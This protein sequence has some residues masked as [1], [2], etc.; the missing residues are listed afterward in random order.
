[1]RRTEVVPGVWRSPLPTARE[2]ADFSRDG[3]KTVVD[4]TRRPRPSIERA[5]AKYALAYR[6]TPLSYIG[7]FSHSEMES[8]VATVLAAETPCLFHCFHGRD[9]TG[10]VARRLAMSVGAVW[11]YR[12]GRNLNRAIRTCEAFNVC[13]LVLVDCDESFISGRLFGAS[14]RVTIERAD[15]LPGDECLPIET[16]GDVEIR[17]VDWAPVRGI[18]IGGET[19]GL[20][21]RVGRSARID[22]GG[23]VS[24]LTVEAAMAVALHEWRGGC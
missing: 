13:R 9:R 1:M 24:G 21:R 2:L 23:H 11:L 18:L 5:C 20:P 17:A 7:S 8:A 10:A 19:S 6:K 4:M 14:G 3:G 15:S 16:W 12:V 22:M